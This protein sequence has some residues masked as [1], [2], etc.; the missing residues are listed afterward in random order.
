MIQYAGY[1]MESWAPT[2][3]FTFRGENVHHTS[4]FSTTRGS[5]IRWHQMV[6]SQKEIVVTSQKPIYF[7]TSLWWISQWLW[8]YQYMHLDRL[9]PLRVGITPVHLKVS[10][11]Y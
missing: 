3:T 8:S 9:N 1:K 2:Y 11:T 7:P 6:P 10:S 4:P 5:F